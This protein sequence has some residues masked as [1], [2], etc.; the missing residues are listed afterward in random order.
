MGAKNKGG[1]KAKGKDAG[2]GKSGK[3]KGNADDATASTKMKGGQSIKVSH[4]LCTKQSKKDEA[5]AAL[6]KETLTVSHFKETAKIYDEDKPKHGGSLGWQTK[7]NLMP[8]FEQV[9]YG[10]QVSKNDK[11]FLGEVKTDHGYHIIMVEDR[12]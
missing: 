9:A 11:V 6:Q 5:L 7:G 10:L 2:G 8:Q 1:D 12:K 4:I 3:G